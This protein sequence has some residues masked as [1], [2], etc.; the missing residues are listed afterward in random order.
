MKGEKSFTVRAYQ[1]AART[2]S[3]LPS[4]ATDMLAR[5]E[6]LTEISGIGKA[7]ADKTA[8]LVD[9]GRLGFLDRLIAEFPPGIPALMDVPGLGLKTT[10]RVWKE[11]GVTDLDQLEAAIETGAL[12]ALPRMGRKSADNILRA[13][14]FSRSKSNRLPISRALAVTRQLTAAILERCSEVDRV[15]PCGGVSRFDEEVEEIVLACVTSKP[16]SVLGAASSLPGFAA[17]L[18]TRDSESTIEFESGVRVTIHVVDPATQGA[19]ILYLIGNSGHV[20][21]LGQRAAEQGFELSERGLAD[22]STGVLETFAGEE[23]LCD[24][25]EMP[26]IRPEERLGGNEITQAVSGDLSKLV[27]LEDVK[28]DLHAHTDW[29]DGRD[30]MAAMVREA[31]GRGLE[32]IAITD[33][34]SGRGIANGLSP[35]R[36]LAH[37]AAVKEVEREVGGIKVLRGTEMDIRADGSVDYSDDLLREL[38]WVV[39]SIHSAMGQESSVMTERII[40]AMNNPHV[41]AIGHL[42]TRLIGERKPIEADY[43]AIFRAAA[44]TGTALEING[45]LERLDLKDARVERARK[46]GAMLVITTDAHTTESLGNLEYGVKVARRGL[47]RVDDILNTMPADKFIFWLKLDKR[48]RIVSSS[49]HD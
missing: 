46:L 27:T 16:K 22:I 35:E 33:H 20:Q 15:I 43:D 47:C 19:A 41:S 44:E 48:S 13:V 32:Y 49:G 7:I 10:L 37:M 38:D 36:L 5:G 9:T 29:S 34:S 45:S 14:Q 12:A 18:V 26:F 6:D 25:L 31:K 39:A 3:R 24:R 1:R 4:E 42:S 21:L 8:E 40:T 30:E 11:L 23:S 28:S 17:L 2:I